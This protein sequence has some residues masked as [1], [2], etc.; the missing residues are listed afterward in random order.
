MLGFLKTNL[1]ILIIILILFSYLGIK[2][3]DENGWDG[4][5]FGSAQTLMSSEYWAKNGFIKNYLLFIPYQYSELVQYFDRPEFR[6]RS[7][8]TLNGELS[9]ARRTH[10]IHYPPLY[11]FPYAI[12][13]KLGIESR[14]TFRVFSLLVSLAGFLF[15]Y[16]FIKSISN[17]T[18]AALASIYY[19]F[20]VTFLNYADSVS[21]QPL[22]IFFTFLILVLSILAGHNFENRKIYQRYNLSI[23]LLYLGLSLSSYDATFFIFAWL[24]L[25]D[26][27]VL[28]KFLWRKWL[29]WTSAPILGFALQIIQNT[30]YLGWADAMRDIYVSYTGR[31]LG[32]L[33]NFILG[34]IMPFVSMTSIKT[35]FIFKKTVVALISAAAILGILWKFRQ[36]IG[37][38]SNY[39][40]IVLILAIAAIIQPFFINITGWWPYQGVLTAPFWGLLVGVSTI[41]IIN[42][43]KKKELNIYKTFS[44][45][46]LA[47]AV[48]ILWSTQFYSTFVYAKDWPNNR[49][50]QKVIDFS[51][52]I[53]K[54]NPGKEKMAFMFVPDNP[55]WKSQFPTFNITYYFGMPKLDYA[56][57]KDLLADFWWL[58]NVSEYPFY[59]FII[60][61]NKT[62]VEKIRRELI[63]K[64]LKN[65]SSIMEMQGQYV[66]IVGSK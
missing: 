29:F 63:A 14:A 24:I 66:I 13:A 21:T 15:F 2:A 58:R 51:K 36:K 48:L 46:V 31:A 60:S 50:D 3:F 49:P 33:K 54:I 9:R 55:I 16:L 30:W 1:L 59:S 22:T 62:D 65:I 61:E 37:L 41:F 64:N 56:N 6:N 57:D 47:A 34:L 26:A 19:G 35:V 20:S 4:W 40:R 44:F 8:E 28:K 23:W 12:M 27:I 25:Y 53:Q 5:G 45:W 52:E 18:V 32:S 43:L 42:V 7:T 10:Y 39:F 17:K 38:D 11:L